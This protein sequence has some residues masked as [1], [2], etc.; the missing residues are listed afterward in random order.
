MRTG[1]IVGIAG[2]DGNGQTELVEAIT[3]L[4]R[5]ESGRIVV[6]GREMSSHANPLA[7]LEAGVGHM[8]EDRHRYGLILDFTLAENAALHDFRYPTRASGGFGRKC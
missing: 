6:E 8:T 4:H 1:E 3:G 2:V 7:M 5:R